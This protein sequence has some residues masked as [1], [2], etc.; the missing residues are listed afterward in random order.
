M[1]MGNRTMIQRGERR[2]PDRHQKVNRNTS[3]TDNITSKRSE[4]RGRHTLAAVRRE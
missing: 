1:V 3:S 2:N 4:N